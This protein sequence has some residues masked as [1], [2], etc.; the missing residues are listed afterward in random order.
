METAFSLVTISCGVASPVS[1]FGW[2][3]VMAAHIFSREIP[4]S[5]GLM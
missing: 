4:A 3:D 2:I 1:G 5:S